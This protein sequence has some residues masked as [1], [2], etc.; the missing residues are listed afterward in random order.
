MSVEKIEKK[1]F[2]VKELA[3]LLGVSRSLIYANVYENEVPAKHIGRR[4]LIPYEFV[5]RTLLQL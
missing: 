3:E 4:V 1:F 2:N 5:E